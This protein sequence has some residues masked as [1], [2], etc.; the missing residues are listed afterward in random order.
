MWLF[1]SSEA[2]ANLRQCLPSL[3]WHAARALVT[4]PRIGEAARAAGFGH[5]TD[6]RPT[7][8]AVAASIESLP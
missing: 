5:V 4:H 8:A 3:D 1:S 7:L 2:I 6:T